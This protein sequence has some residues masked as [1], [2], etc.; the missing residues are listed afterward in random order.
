M[1]KIGVFL[2]DSYLFFFCLQKKASHQQRN[3]LKIIKV[4]INNYLKTRISV[5]RAD[6]RLSAGLNVRVNSSPRLLGN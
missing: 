1:Q 3:A 6:S 4:T 2:Y 5:T